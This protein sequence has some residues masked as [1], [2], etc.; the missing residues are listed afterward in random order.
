MKNP[1]TYE[2]NA[3][4]SYAEKLQPP[5][6]KN[7]SS[8]F[9]RSP[10]NA[11]AASLPSFSVRIVWLD[12]AALSQI[13]KMRAKDCSVLVIHPFLVAVDKLANLESRAVK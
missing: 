5:F 2:H 9:V 13:A 4:I 8:L 11:F 3:F 10:R 12:F 1:I 6:L 7:A